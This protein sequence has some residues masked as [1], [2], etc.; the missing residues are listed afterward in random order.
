MGD[1]WRVERVKDIDTCK[2]CKYF[3]QHYI[4]DSYGFTA[5]NAGH[6]LNTR[7]KGRTC[8]SKACKDFERVG[9]WKI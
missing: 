6:C 2:G 1:L 3:L 8:D 4:R 5:C 9:K 7:K